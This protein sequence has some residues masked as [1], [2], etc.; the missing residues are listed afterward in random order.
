MYKTKEKE[1]KT[2]LFTLVCD[3]LTIL[4]KHALTLHLDYVAKKR[5]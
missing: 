5:L 3:A 2:A 1:K 4:S